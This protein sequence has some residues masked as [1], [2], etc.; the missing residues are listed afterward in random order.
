MQAC[1]HVTK[2]LFL[3]E[4]NTCRLNAAR[5]AVS[6]SSVAC[7]CLSGRRMVY[8]HQQQ[9]GPP[10][11]RA[12]LKTNLPSADY[13]RIYRHAGRSWSTTSHCP[14]IR[15]RSYEIDIEMR[16]LM[17]RKYLFLKYYDSCHGQ[18]SVTGQSSRP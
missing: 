9:V 5:K 18:I 10:P 3:C 7:A 8:R 12:D 17:Y 1:S 6:S 4:I 14:Q 15:R 16:F 13:T 2:A 11:M